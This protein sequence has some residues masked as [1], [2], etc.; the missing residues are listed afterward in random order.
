ME[1]QNH[2]N[3]NI[4]SSSAELE[5]SGK[6]LFEALTL[7][8]RR[9]R[10]LVMKRHGKRIAMKRQRALKRRAQ[11]NALKKRA[12]K[13]ARMVLTK[14]MLKGRDLSKLTISDKQN[15]EKKLEAKKG[16]IAKLAKKL[17]PIVKKEEEERMAKRREKESEKGKGS[18][19]K[20]STMN[21]DRKKLTFFEFMQQTVRG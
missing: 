13:K 17:L 14:K 6:T 21:V 12:L 18:D 19:A 16:L 15:L 4:N 11:P 2:N 8:Q 5:S 10:S 3:N 7:Q 20:E 9:K 1:I